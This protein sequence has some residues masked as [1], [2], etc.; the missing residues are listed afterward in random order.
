MWMCH[1][2]R[3]KGLKGQALV[4]TALVLPI[5]LLLFLGIIQFGFIFFADITLN[6]LSREGA[7]AVAVGAAS[8]SETEENIE[9]RAEGFRIIKSADARV[10]IV[11][12]A[13]MGKN[14]TAELTGEVPVFTPLL[15]RMFAPENLH[16]NHLKL[17]AR[18]TMRMEE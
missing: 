14:V 17:Y 6:N 7:R 3:T 8:P 18:T 1:R 10:W 13:S 15:R 16:E 11:D 5:L 2:K 9:S 4:E 12:D